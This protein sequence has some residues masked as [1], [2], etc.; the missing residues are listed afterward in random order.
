VRHASRARTLC[1]PEF[2]GVIFFTATPLDCR[3]D[4]RGEKRLPLFNNKALGNFDFQDAGAI[5]MT[6]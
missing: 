5:G 1:H 2:P 3:S 4:L 6:V